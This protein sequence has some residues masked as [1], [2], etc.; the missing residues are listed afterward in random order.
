MIEAAIVGRP[1][2]SIR[3]DGF[4]QD[5]TLHFRLLLPEG[6]GPVEVAA[7]LPEHR[8]QL[9]AALADPGPAQER[10]E[11]FVAGFV[12]PL[13]RDRPATTI[14][15]DAIEEVGG[16]GDPVRPLPRRKVWAHVLSRYRGVVRYVARRP[17]EPEVRDES[18]VSEIYENHYASANAAY[19][20]SRDMRRD[21]FFEGRTPVFVNGWY[22][23][24]FHADLLAEHLDAPPGGSV[25][26]VGSGRGTNLA[27]LAMN[28]P[29]LSLTGLELTREGVARARELVTD[30]PAPHVH[31]AGFARLDDEQRAALSRVEFHQASALEMPFDDDSFDVSFTCL[32]LEQLWGGHEQVLREMRRVTR[33]HCVFL[34]PFADANGPL[35]KAYLRSLDYFRARSGDFAKYGLEPVSFTTDIPQ[36]VH[37]RTGLLVCRVLPEPVAQV[38][39][40]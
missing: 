36:K 39:R 14:L 18:K 28:R 16:G 23:I 9:A 19:A 21:V 22:T 6:G 32:V 15:A 1:V 40:S 27:L 29:D 30:P 33:S 38:T 10:A 24:R 4:A 5:S 11:R 35:G 34:E 17:S 25:L 26:E 37:F 7:S 3:A 31:A 13:G 8:R 2:L 12:R 20:R